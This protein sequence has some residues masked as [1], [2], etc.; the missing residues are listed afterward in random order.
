MFTF[1]HCA[2]S[3][4]DL[5]TSINFYRC[6]GFQ[7]AVIWESPDGTLRIAHLKLGENGAILELFGYKSNVAAPREIL[8]PGNDLERVGVKHLGLQVSSLTEAKKFLADRDLPQG[9]DIT[10]G[11]TGID[12]FFVQDPDGLWLE[13]VEDHRTLSILDL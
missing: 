7:P 9:T 11:R 3:V 12:Y 10:H 2:L 1:H 8:S 4:G 6:F 13:I 5:D